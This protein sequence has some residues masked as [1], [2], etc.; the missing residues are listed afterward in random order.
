MLKH[1]LSILLGFFINIGIAMSSSLPSG[2]V[3]LSDIDPTIIESVRYFGSDNFLGKPV[4]GYTVNR[5]ICTEKAAVAL[6]AV[7]DQLKKEG[8]YLVVYD[9]YRPQ[10]AVNAF[11]AWE[12]D[13]ADIVAKHLYY[14]TLSKK[15]IF[16]LGY[17]SPRS[18]HTRGSTFD[19]TLIPIRNALK[20]IMVSE[21]TLTNHEKIPFL[22]DNTLDMGSSFD[23]FHPVSHTTT[24]LISSQA[25]QHRDILNNAMVKGG[26]QGYPEE[27]WHYLLKDEPYPDTYF[28]FVAERKVP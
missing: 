4:A 17:V 3:F 20:P 23:L 27:W 18:Q 10:R 15:D 13:S 24:P 14:P 11:I 28:D 26:F 12:H 22:D 7:H 9:G 19:L 16:R 1:F 5:I 21:R 25:Q 6:K 2:F 8:Y